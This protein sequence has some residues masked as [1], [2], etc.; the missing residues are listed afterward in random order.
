M[1]SDAFDDTYALGKIYVLVLIPKCLLYVYRLAY[2]CILPMS[3]QKKILIERHLEYIKIFD[4]AP[5]NVQTA[6]K[7]LYL[8]FKQWFVTQHW[9]LYISPCPDRD[10][11]VLSISAIVQ[12]YGCR[13][14][15]WD[16]R[17]NFVR[18]SHNLDLTF[19]AKKSK[20][21][22]ERDLAWVGIMRGPVKEYR[23]W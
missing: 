11:C 8:V 13:I 6:V 14:G 16:F 22:P 5:S 9:A 15:V 2:W 7:M 10:L 21:R 1:L 18:T 23:W 20:T 17:P 3:D 12:T 19:L 4:W